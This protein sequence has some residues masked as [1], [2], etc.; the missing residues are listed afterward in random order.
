MKNVFSAILAGGIFAAGVMF[1]APLSDV[2][3]T[4]P[5]AVTVGSTT[6]PSGTYTMS[7]METSDGTD[8]F[9]LRGEETA[10]LVLPVQKVERSAA[11]RTSVS[12]SEDGDTWKFEQLSLQGETTA[13]SFEK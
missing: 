10:P 1:A 11:P 5:H 4:V 3:V 9:V 8:Y 7:P 6:L 2:T 13:Y 12:F